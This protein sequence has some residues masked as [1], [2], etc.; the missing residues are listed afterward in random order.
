MIVGHN[1]CACVLVLL[2]C[3]V[4]MKKYSVDVMSWFGSV[5]VLYAIGGSPLGAIMCDFI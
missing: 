1:V 3:F 4:I 5:I 2:G